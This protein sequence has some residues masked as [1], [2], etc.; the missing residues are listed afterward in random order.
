MVVAGWGGSLT[1]LAG[2]ASDAPLNPS[3]PL[4]RDEAP[5][6]LKQMNDNQRALARPVV[7]LGGI[8]DPGFVA[9]HIADVIRDTVPDRTQVIHVSFFETG[10]FDACA[11]KLI[12]NSQE[13]FPADEPHQT[14][15]VDIVAFSMGGLVARHAASNAYASTHDR[16]LH[17]ARLFTIS[18]PHIGADMA[19]LPTF[20]QRIRD[21]REGSIFLTQ[22]NQGDGIDQR[23][24]P[25]T[26]PGATVSNATAPDTPVPEAIMLTSQPE[27]A[28]RNGYRLFA[29]VRLNDGVI[30]EEHA[31][32]PGV[33]AW[34]VPHGLSFSH[35]LAGF[36]NRILADIIR[37]LRD[38]EPY[39]IEP[40]A[41]LP[42]RVTND[43]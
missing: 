33:T 5:A 38:E 6:A 10:S 35:L 27:G 34:W 4:T 12:R 1:A 32:P 21:M 19:K 7:V 24:P 18:T 13:H 25:A 26:M 22:L 36:D 39:S 40:A 15:E 20:D 9:P 3:F 2:C 11:S 17:M 42:E 14:V 43:E 41:P 8:L 16:R 28:E 31:A 29:Y 30:G 37:R 23:Q